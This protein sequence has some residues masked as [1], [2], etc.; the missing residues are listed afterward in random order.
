MVR[1]CPST[2]GSRLRGEFTVSTL[3]TVT[4]RGSHVWG[5]A[6]QHVPSTVLWCL[7]GADTVHVSFARQPILDRDGRL[8]GY[9]L[10]VPERPSP[11]GAMAALSGIDLRAAG[12]GTDVFLD[13]TPAVLLAFDPLPF[14]PEG[15]VLELAASRVG[16]PNLLARI[17]SLRADGYSVALDGVRAGE[18][19]GSL[20]DLVTHV[21]VDARTLGGGDAAEIVRRITRHGAV[22]AAF[23]VATREQRDLLAEAGFELLQGDFHCRPRALADPPAPS[24]IAGLRGAMQVAAAGDPEALILAISRDPGLSVRLLRFMNSAAFSLRHRVSSVPHAVRLLGPR[25]VRQWATLV[26]VAGSDVAVPEPL[27]TSA[28]ARGRTCETLAERL[29]MDDREAYF[30]VGLLSTADAMLDVPLETAIAGL[31][32]ADDITAALLTGAGGKGRALRMALA[33]ERGLGDREAIPGLDGDA[34]RDL[35]AEALGWADGVVLGLGAD[36]PVAVSAA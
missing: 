11:A 18:A 26:L 20:L 19:D 2:S 17:G 29:G 6:G 13:V 23:E 5:P 12:G 32:L 3:D 28:L 30:L 35:H 4:I 36:A 10:L 16:D 8:A 9:E 21:K 22:A 27:L 24:S 25:A 7:P 33:C 34:L 31:P 1:P 14:E 15:I